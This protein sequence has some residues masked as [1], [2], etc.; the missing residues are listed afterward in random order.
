MVA[1]EGGPQ[2][3]APGAATTLALFSP[4]GRGKAPAH[5][6]LRSTSLREGKIQMPLDQS[7]VGQ[8][9]ASQMEA[10]EADYGDDCEIG[11]ICTIVEIRGPHGSHVRMRS[12]A[13]SPHS[14][15][16]LLKLAEQVALANF[17]RDDV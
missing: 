8:H 12:T 3:V 6:R 9:I 1:S 7:K 2:A 15:L 13:S 10:I 17:G 4:Y 11:D 5:G 16:G 14:T